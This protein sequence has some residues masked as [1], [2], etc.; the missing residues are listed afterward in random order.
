[1]SKGRKAEKGEYIGVRFEGDGTKKWDGNEVELPGKTVVMLREWTEEGP[2]RGRFYPS[3][4]TRY[5]IHTLSL[6]QHYPFTYV[7]TAEVPWR[8][9]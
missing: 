5:L 9:P 3:I 8:Y 6:P 7:S 4:T 1:M 2:E